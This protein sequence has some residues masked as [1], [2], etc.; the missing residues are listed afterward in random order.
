MRKQG[1]A[2]STLEAVM[3]RGQVIHLCRAGGGRRI[4]D[5]W[6]LP[7]LNGDWMKLNERSGES[8]KEDHD[9]ADPYPEDEWI[10][11]R[12]DFREAGILIAPFVDHVE[13][14]QPGEW[15]AT[16]VSTVWLAL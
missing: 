14:P 1:G 13:I 16:T 10:Q 7:L 8:A 12:F 9:S 6:I 11:E 15:F 3:R 5:H 2:V 4:G